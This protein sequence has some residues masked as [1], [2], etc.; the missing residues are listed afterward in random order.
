[1]SADPTSAAATATTATTAGPD[2][3]AVAGNPVAHSRSP[4]IHAAFAAQTGQSL[5]YERLLCPLDGFEAAIRDFVAS[6]ARGCNV[7]VPFKF[8]AFRLAARRTPRAA[9]AGAVNTLR[10][11]TDGG[12]L[13]DNTDGAGLVADIVEFW[14]LLGVPVDRA[15]LRPQ[16]AQQSQQQARLAG[17]VGAAQQQQAARAEGKAEPREQR[18]AAAAQG[19]I[20]DAQQRIARVHGRHAYRGPIRTGKCHCG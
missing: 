10:F 8:D 5:V 7:T 12:W 9:L 6:G 14:P 17:A 2:R 20:L 19:Q 16:D 13:G 15:R 11:D 1:M 3:Y 18:P 4:E